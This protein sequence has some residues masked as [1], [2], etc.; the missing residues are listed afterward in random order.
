MKQESVISIKTFLMIEACPMTLF[1]KEWKNFRTKEN[2]SFCRKPCTNQLV[3]I[4]IL[5][6]QS[7]QLPSQLIHLCVQTMIKIFFYWVKESIPY[8]RFLTCNFKILRK[9]LR[10]NRLVSLIYLLSQFQIQ[11]AYLK[12]SALIKRIPSTIC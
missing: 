12:R 7:L 10:L 3:I 1:G 9:C 6:I 5:F 4:Q 8:N 2:L 11:L